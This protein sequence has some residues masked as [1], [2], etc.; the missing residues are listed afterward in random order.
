MPRVKKFIKS[1]RE[2]KTSRG[3][4]RRIWL[5]MEEEQEQNLLLDII[6]NSPTQPSLNETTELPLTTNE[7]TK[8]PH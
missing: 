7:T 2:P 3:H 4:G 8:C 6:S 1:R 5:V